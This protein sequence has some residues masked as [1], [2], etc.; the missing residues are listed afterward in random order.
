MAIAS[1]DTSSQGISVLYVGFL[2]FKKNYETMALRIFLRIKIE[3][4]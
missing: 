4:C 1:Y 3:L 2:F